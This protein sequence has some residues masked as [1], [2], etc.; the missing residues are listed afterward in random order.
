M[1]LTP[2]S[3]RKALIKSD[4]SRKDAAV[5]LKVSADTLRIWIRR[6]RDR[7][8]I[9]PEPE[10]EVSRAAK[11]YSI[12][13][14]G[15]W[16]EYGHDQESCEVVEIYHGKALVRHES[17]V[18]AWVAKRQLAWVPSR[19]VIAEATRRIRDAWPAGEHAKRARWAISGDYEIPQVSS[20]EDSRDVT[21]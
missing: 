6:F 8:E 2:D 20:V 21:W 19:A 1:S 15:Q 13:Q 3:I 10:N 12:I 11:F 17:G 16:V 5:T 9:F 18:E 4:G 7:G 14:P